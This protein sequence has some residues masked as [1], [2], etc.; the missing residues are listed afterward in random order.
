LSVCHLILDVPIQYRTKSDT[1]N[2]FQHTFD[3][4]KNLAKTY[5]ETRE[6]MIT[7]LKINDQETYDAKLAE[8]LYTI[9]QTYAYIDSI[10]RIY[11]NV[12]I[13]LKCM[14]FVK[15]INLLNVEM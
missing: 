11:M 12:I 10:N 1:N 6:E 7:I 3:H 15:K 5:Y 13:R 8:L 9:L 2:N 14:I 4:S